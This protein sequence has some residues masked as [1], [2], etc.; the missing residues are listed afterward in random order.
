MYVNVF[1]ELILTHFYR[2]LRDRYTISIGCKDMHF[3]PLDTSYLPAFVPYVISTIIEEQQ[4]LGY[5]RPRVEPVEVMDDESQGSRLITAENG[6]GVVASAHDDG[7]ENKQGVEE[8]EHHSN[9][10]MKSYL[11]EKNVKLPAPR[12]PE[13]IKIA[14]DFLS[15]LDLKNN[16]GVQDILVGN[17]LRKFVLYVPM[18]TARYCF[19]KF[20]DLELPR[21]H[22]TYVM[23]ALIEP[24]RIAP[25]VF[26]AFTY[27]S[28]RENADDVYVLLAIW[29]TSSGKTTFVLL[30]E[31]TSEVTRRLNTEM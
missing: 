3:G 31:K 22:N 25:T 21:L 8:V 9:T 24:A 19:L 27:L 29:L 23:A 13:E 16:F 30:N 11:G 28:N 26:I 4:S 10:L 1:I 20:G 18:D 5:V 6:V 15:Y 17:R 14:A 2:L 7:R 12:S